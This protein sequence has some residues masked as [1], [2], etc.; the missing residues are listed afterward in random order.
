MSSK[1]E[2]KPAHIC[3]YFHFLTKQTDRK[4]LSPKICEAKPVMKLAP[5]QIPD[6]SAL[7]CVYI[8]ELYRCVC[9]IMYESTCIYTY[10]FKCVF[11]P[12]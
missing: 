1:F 12:V 8:H 11:M 5:I 10:M 9:I 7:T 4:S 2:N 6:I 3:V